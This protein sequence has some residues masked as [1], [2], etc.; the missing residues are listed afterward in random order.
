MMRREN[1]AHH[2]TRETIEGKRSRGAQ[3][4]KNDVGWTN[5]VAQTRTSDRSTKSGEGPRCVEGQ[6]RLR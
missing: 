6:D 5:K 4:E 2:V 1:L 3:R